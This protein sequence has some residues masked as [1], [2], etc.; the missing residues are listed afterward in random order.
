MVYQTYFFSRNISTDMPKYAMKS[1][2]I[3]LISSYKNFLCRFSQKIT[4]L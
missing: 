2:D 1:S 4:A 3:I